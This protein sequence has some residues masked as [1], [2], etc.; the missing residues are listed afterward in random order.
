MKKNNK[1]YEKLVYDR[2]LKKDDPDK[3]YPNPADPNE[4]KGLPNKEMPVT[5]NPHLDKFQDENQK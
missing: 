3:R 4:E 1:D 2:P 5:S